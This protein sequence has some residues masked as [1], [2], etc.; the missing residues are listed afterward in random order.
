[1]ILIYWVGPP[2]THLVTLS[3]PL[4]NRMGE[5]NKM[6]KLVGC[7]KGGVI[8]KAKAM[9]ESKA[10]GGNLFPTSCSLPAYWPFEKDLETQP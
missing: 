4:L 9:H 8:K 5:E 2:G 6:D 1:M 10:K 3:L 7:D